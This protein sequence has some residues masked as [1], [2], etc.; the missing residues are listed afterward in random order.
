MCGCRT[1]E[2][3]GLTALSVDLKQLRGISRSSKSHRLTLAL[4][5]SDIHNY[6]DQD[7]KYHPGENATG[8]LLRAKLPHLCIRL[9]K[10]QGTF[11]GIITEINLQDNSC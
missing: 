7:T 2:R 9:S 1:Q 4:L 5:L 6:S 3:G 11:K 8:F 10:A